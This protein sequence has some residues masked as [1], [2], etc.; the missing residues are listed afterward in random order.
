M[1]VVCICS[2][3]NWA[4][5]PLCPHR[6]CLTSFS[7][8]YCK[9]NNISYSNEIR[10][11]TRLLLV[12]VCVGDGEFTCEVIF[13]KYKHCTIVRVCNISDQFRIYFC[14]LTLRVSLYIVDERANIDDVDDNHHEAV[15]FLKFNFI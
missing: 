11:D 9:I 5:Q 15:L 13:Y 14:V 8:D 1:Y 12:C 2:W 4:L 6:R 3:F 7:C 10:F